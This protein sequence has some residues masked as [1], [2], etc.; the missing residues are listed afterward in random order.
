ML[1]ISDLGPPLSGY[2]AYFDTLY[3][4][5][6]DRYSKK[7]PY[8][9]TEIARL[10]LSKVLPE[11]KKKTGKLLVSFV[12]NHPLK[13]MEVRKLIAI[14]RRYVAD[15]CEKILELSQIRNVG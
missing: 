14:N 3:E 15:F 4:E 13:T 1:E 7:Y 6:L 10:Y 5:Y 11:F 12:R 2:R 8:K 9:N